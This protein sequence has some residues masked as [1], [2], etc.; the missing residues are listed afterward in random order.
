MP[1]LAP[2]TLLDAAGRGAE[3]A[4]AGGSI[5]NV[6]EAQAVAALVSA[7]LRVGGGGGGNGSGRA[8][9]A[10]GEGEE[11]EEE[12][13]CAVSA[14]SIGVICLCEYFFYGVCRFRVVFYLCGSFNLP[15]VSFVALQYL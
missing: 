3:S 9:A 1:G 6:F 7:L 10:G 14:A 5:R 2:L 13:A 8:R 11:E 15:S 4:A 12:E